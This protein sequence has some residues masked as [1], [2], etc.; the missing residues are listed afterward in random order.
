MRG[1][2]DDGLSEWYPAY[3]NI[4]KASECQTNHEQHAFQ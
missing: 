1:W 3:A 4:Q 2:R